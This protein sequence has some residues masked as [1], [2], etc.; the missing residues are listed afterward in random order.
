MF[1]NLIA[2]LIS[3]IRVSIQ[4]KRQ[5]GTSHYS[6]FALNILNKLQEKNIVGKIDINIKNRRKY[7][8]FELPN[9][10]YT[11]FISEIFGAYK[12]SAQYYFKY[13]EIPQLLQK[14]SEG[15][16]STNLGVLYLHECMA[17]KVGGRLILLY[18]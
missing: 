10:N 13:T 9:Y 5:N 12:A 7:I 17:K 4:H 14:H 15:L 3:N 16:I 18:R 1:N 6:K 2:N 11:Y 8:D